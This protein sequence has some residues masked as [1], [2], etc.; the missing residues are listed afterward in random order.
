M[1][2]PCYHTPTVCLPSYH[3]PIT[4]LYP[5]HSTGTPYHPNGIPY[6]SNAMPPWLVLSQAPRPPRRPLPLGSLLVFRWRQSSIFVFKMAKPLDSRCG[7]LSNPTPLVPRA[8]TKTKTR[9]ESRF[10]NKKVTPYLFNGILIY[11]QVATFADAF[12]CAIEV[13]ESMRYISDI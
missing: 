10:C 9:L 5:Y 6:H 7:L 3:R 11:F 8:P 13:R 2:P 12:M 4:P 1:H